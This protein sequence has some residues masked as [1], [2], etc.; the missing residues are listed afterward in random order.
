MKK[1]LFAFLM[2]IASLSGFSQSF[3]VDNKSL[4]VPRYANQAAIN[5]ANPTP[6]AGRLVYD[7]SLN[8]YAY[9]NGSAWTNFPTSSSPA[10][11]LWS[12]NQTTGRIEANSGAPAGIEANRF[13]SNGVTSATAPLINSIG[14]ANTFVRFGHPQGNYAIMQE[15]TTG[16]SVNGTSINW[17]YYD[18]ANPQ[19]ITNLFGYTGSTNTFTH[20][21]FTKLGDEATTTTAGVTKSS[22]AIKTLLLTGSLTPG[23]SPET[24]ASLLT[25]VPHGLNY[26]KIIET[27][28]LV[29]GVGMNGGFLVEPNFVDSR[30]VV[31]GLQYTTYNDGNNVYIIRNGTNSTN[32]RPVAG[33]T[34]ATYRI[35]IT[36]IP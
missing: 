27:K 6:T 24:N 22:P 30:G 7:N 12:L 20:N 1:V 29:N 33:A 34:T 23:S 13:T 11:N 28:V 21:S 31:T 17:R 10:S 16:F 18:N 3:S 4:S 2:I 25:T 5:T 36:Y 15:S 32:I 19:V 14:N 9:Y 26:S 35:L 8:Q